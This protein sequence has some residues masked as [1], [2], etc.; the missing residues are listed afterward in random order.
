[1]LTITQVAEEVQF[2]RPTVYGWTRERCVDGKPVLPVV[3]FG[4]Q[5]R[6]TRAAVEAL[7]KRLS[8]RVPAPRF[9]FFAD[10]GVKHG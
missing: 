4:R 7:P 6:V 1:M 2:A 3:R 9:S 5:V 8:L 10:E